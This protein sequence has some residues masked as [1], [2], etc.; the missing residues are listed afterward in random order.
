M[1]NAIEGKKSKDIANEMST[2]ERILNF[3]K[4]LGPM[5]FIVIFVFNDCLFMIRELT[6]GA[7]SA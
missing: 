3:S 1:K 5:L 4:L 7:N 6:W 2:K